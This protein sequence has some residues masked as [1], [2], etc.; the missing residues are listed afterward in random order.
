MEFWADN[1]PRNYINNSIRQIVVITEL[2]KAYRTRG[3][4]TVQDSLNLT[5]IHETPQNDMN[6][7]RSICF[8]YTNSA[9]SFVIDRNYPD[10]LS[11]GWLC[12]G[13]PRN[14]VCIPVPVC[15]EKLD[16]EIAGLDF[17]R[18]ARKDFD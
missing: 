7:T 6:L 5:R 8:K 10:V 13:P 15:V 1:N 4:I 2:N 14:T 18:A 9:S 3:R 11:T 16:P 17:Y 12:V